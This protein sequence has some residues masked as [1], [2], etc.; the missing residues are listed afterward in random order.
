MRR[1]EEKVIEV[2]KKG[3]APT[4]L[5]RPMTVDSARRSLVRPTAVRSPVRS[6]VR[7]ASARDPQ[8]TRRDNAITGHH[9]YGQQ[10]CPRDRRDGRAGVTATAGAHH[11]ARYEQRRSHSAR[12]AISKSSDPIPP[13]R[14]R[15]RAGFGIDDLEERHSGWSSGAADSPSRT[16]GQAG[17]PGRSPQAAA[18]PDG[19]Y[20]VRIP[21]GG[22]R[23]RGL[24][25]FVIEW[26]TRPSARP[27]RKARR[28]ATARR[29][30]MRRAGQKMIDQLGLVA[31]K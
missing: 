19:S 9:C 26:G 2:V 25:P 24:G 4:P 1:G 22:C 18:R 27:R 15:G 8:Q 21:I 30:P 20:L 3:L 7:D 6:I 29:H 12:R 14:S 11:R 5:A 17:S 10:T 31:R 13:S 23:R 28:R 16:T